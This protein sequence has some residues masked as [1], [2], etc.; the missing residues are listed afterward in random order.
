MLSN[1]DIERYRRMT[2][3]E[4]LKETFEL[5]GVA[6]RAL[7]ALPAADRA[8]RLAIVE[9]EHRAS[10]AELLRRLAQAQ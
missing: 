4:R 9:A 7:A 3:A 5:C 8:R 2:P 10:N 1:R 6:E